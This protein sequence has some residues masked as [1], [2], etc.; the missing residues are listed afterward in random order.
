M[1]TSSRERKAMYL[2]YIQAKNV[3]NTIECYR[4]WFSKFLR[5]LPR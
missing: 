5:V 3:N 4:Q 2:D 1:N